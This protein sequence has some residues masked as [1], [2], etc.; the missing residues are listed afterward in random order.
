MV[1]YYYASARENKKKKCAA[2]TGANADP[3]R[4]VDDPRGYVGGASSSPTSPSA[5]LVGSGS[6]RAGLD[7][8]TRTNLPSSSD[9]YTPGRLTG[10]HRAREHQRK[11]SPACTR[12]LAL[13]ERIRA[14]R[15]KL[16]AEETLGYTGS[17]GGGGRSD[18]GARRQRTSGTAAGAAEVAGGEG[19]DQGWVL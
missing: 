10:D 19:I 11:Q 7:T 3:H 15:E 17:D 5:A 6:N 12:V 14:Q 8:D 13:K 2:E 18:V 16:L 1:E 9:G 4:I